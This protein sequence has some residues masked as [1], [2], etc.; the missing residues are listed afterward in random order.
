MAFRFAQPWFLILL[1]VIP[2]YLYYELVIRSRKV[3]GLPASRLAL[4]M[5]LQGSHNLYRYFYPALKSLLILCLILALARPQWGHGVRDLQKNGVDI[6]IAMDVSG[7]MLA[8]DFMPQNRL[9]AA[10]KVAKDF[11]SRRPNDRFSLVA[12]S[13]YAITA[14]PLTWD[15]A[16][17]M[18]AL[19]HLEVNMEASGTAV[20]MGLAKAVARLKDS[21]AKS[22]IVVLITDGVNNTGEIDPLAAARMAAALGIKVYP[23]GVGSGGLVP[24]PY[25][26]PFFGT[27][28]IPTLI[29]LDM[30]TLDQIAA[31]TGTKK[32]ANATD[33]AGLR[34]IMLELDKLERTKMLAR[35]NYLWEDRFHLLLLAA[36]FL[37]LFEIICKSFWLPVFPE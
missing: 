28:N 27:R 15:H 6:V 7:S 25:A 33:A 2:L 13:E 17:V 26:D 30:L 22:R 24:F 10:V 34:N 19:D 8:L 1:L 20:G 21:K 9:G 14:S 36:M 4:L 5:E 37:L 23:I 3:N 16:S 18:A 35:M 11:V 29:E 32:A 31:L 12:F